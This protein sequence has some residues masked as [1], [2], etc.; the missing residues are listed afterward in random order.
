MSEVSTFAVAIICFFDN[1]LFDYNNCLFY[2]SILTLQDGLAGNEGDWMDGEERG[3][4]AVGSW[5][6]EGGTKGPIVHG[7][8]EGEEMQQGPT[9]KNMGTDHNTR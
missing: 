1:S 3:G 4:T 2:C 6:E 9:G 5:M 7:G 8:G